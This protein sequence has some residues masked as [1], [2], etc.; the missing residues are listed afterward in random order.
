MLGVS[1]SFRSFSAALD[2]VKDA[3]VFAGIHFRTATEVGSALGAAVG[4]WVLENA[5][6]RVD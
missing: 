2:E 5:F 6:Q 1:R 3:R 4:Q